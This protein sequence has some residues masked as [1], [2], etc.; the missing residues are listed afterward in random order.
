MVGPTDPPMGPRRAAPLRGFVVDLSTPGSRRYRLVRRLATLLAAGALFTLPFQLADPFALRLL[1]VMAMYAT[2]GIAWNILGGYA[3]QISIGHSIFFGLGA[4]TSTL[5]FLRLGWSPWL[6]LLA[7]MVVAATVAV[8]IGFPCFLL[9]GHYFVIA[10]AVLAESASIL[11]TTWEVVGSALG[12]QLPIL[13]SSLANFQ[14]HESK[15]PYYYL[16]LGM[17]ALALAT[18]AVIER[19]KLG[20]CLKAIREDEFAAMSLAIN[21]RRYKLVAMAVSAALTAMVGTFYAQFVL[22]VDPPSVLPLSLSVMIALVPIL[23]GIG[24]L[25]GPVAGAAVLIPI[26]ELTRVLLSGG[27]RNLDLIVY[28]VLI[29][30]ISVWRPMG[31]LGHPRREEPGGPRV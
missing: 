3:G 23:G 27:G 16:S 15:A 30:A 28:G 10:T 21:I 8:L 29:M 13:P 7:G 2:L 18:A 1:T 20:Y 6:G 9:K 25:W 11:F 17:L 14:F 26:S 22:F 19:S 4:Y 31:L 5:L 24:T 12:L